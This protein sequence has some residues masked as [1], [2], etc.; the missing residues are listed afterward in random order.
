MNILLI[1]YLQN[2][3]DTETFWIGYEILL[4]RNVIHD[5]AH[6]ISTSNNADNEIHT[7]NIM[8]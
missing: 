4:I 5:I 3:V 7:C 8:N 6:E 2:S 1:E